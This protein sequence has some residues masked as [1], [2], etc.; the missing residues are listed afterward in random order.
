MAEL[1]PTIDIAGWDEPDPGRRDAIAAEVDAACSTVGFAQVAGHGVHPSLVAGMSAA[2]DRIFAL[3]LEAKLA[4]VPPPHINRGYAPLGSESLTYS[5]GVDS[6]PDQFEAFN[7]G[8]EGFDPDDPVYASRRDGVF[9]PNLWPDGLRAERT[10]LVA[11]FD[12]VAGLAHRLTSIFAVALGLQEDFFADQTDH[13]TDT[14]RCNHYLAVAN[15]GAAGPGPGQMG[16]GAHTDYGIVTVLHGDPVPGLEIVGPDGEW[17]PVVPEPDHFLINLGDLLARWTNDRWRSTVHR[18]VPPG[19][20]GRSG[21]PVRRRS[22]AFFHDGNDDAW[23]ACLPTCLAP[24]QEPRYPPVRAGEH[25]LEKV[26]TART[27]TTRPDRHRHDTVGDRLA[28]VTRTL[29]TEPPTTGGDRSRPAGAGP[30]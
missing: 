27:R 14:L 13:S 29:A 4:L 8:P 15:A 19:G 1:V 2:S 5:L 9:A 25:M 20:P 30:G 16:M 7:I 21:Q 28:A 10:A 24:G 23:V 11:Y 26:L 22:A 3:P 12:A 17:H 18:V 6:P